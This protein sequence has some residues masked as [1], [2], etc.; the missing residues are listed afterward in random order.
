MEKNESL[1]IMM[2]VEGGGG[3]GGGGRGGGGGGGGISDI[4][5]LET[6]TFYW[7][8]LKKTELYSVDFPRVSAS[9]YNWGRHPWGSM[10]TLC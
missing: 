6:F 3:G 5:F 8:N 2:V 4:Q 1:K 10:R 7:N 9:F